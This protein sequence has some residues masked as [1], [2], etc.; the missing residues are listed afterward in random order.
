MRPSKTT[1]LLMLAAAA[2][3]TWFATALEVQHRRTQLLVPADYQRCVTV[4]TG[5]LKPPP[6]P[7][8][9][10]GPISEIA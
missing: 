6:R 8:H 3:I 1:L 10:S 4:I 2:W 7:M 9:G 5:P